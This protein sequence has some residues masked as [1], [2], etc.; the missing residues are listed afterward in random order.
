MV[1]FILQIKMDLENIEKVCWPEDT[2]WCMDIKNPSGQLDE[3]RE[4]ITVNKNDKEDIPN[5]KNNTCNFLCKWE[6][7]KQVSSE[8]LRTLCFLFY[9][10]STLCA[11]SSLDPAVQLLARD[12]AYP[13]HKR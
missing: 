6:D 1:V 11:T 5:T 13:F 12:Y 10:T 3:V 8:S 2:Y 7:A 4:R 9:L